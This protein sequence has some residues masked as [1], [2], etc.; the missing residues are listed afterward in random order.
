MWRQKLK[1]FSIE[2]KK[3]TLNTKSATATISVSADICSFLMLSLSA[4]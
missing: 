3:F 2:K 4:W 1:M